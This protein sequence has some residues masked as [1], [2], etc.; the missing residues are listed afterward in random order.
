MVKNKDKFEHKIKYLEMMQNIIDRMGRN[1]FAIKNWFVVALSGILT[2]M[3]SQGKTDVLWAGICLSAF[4]WVLDAYYLNLERKY[5]AKYTDALTGASPLFDMDI[6]KIKK[7][8]PILKLMFSKS[9]SLYW[10]GI[11]I[12]FMSA[13]AE[14]IKHMYNCLIICM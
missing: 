7:N 11:I 8:T 3:F 1:S 6:S 5:R 10:V 13:Y 12:L 9:L 4:L 14:T 2:L